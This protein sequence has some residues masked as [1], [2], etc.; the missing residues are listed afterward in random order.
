MLQRP[1]DIQSFIKLLNLWNHC[2][3][4]WRE[5]FQCEWVLVYVPVHIYSL[6]QCITFPLCLS[7]VL[8][9][10]GSRWRYSEFDSKQC[11]NNGFDYDSF[12]RSKSLLLTSR[13]WIICSWR[14]KNQRVWN[15]KWY[16]IVAYRGNL[17]YKLPWCTVAELQ[18]ALSFPVCTSLYATL[19]ERVY[20][21]CVTC[22]RLVCV[23]WD[24][25]VFLLRYEETYWYVICQTHTHIHTLQPHAALCFPLYFTHTNTH[26]CTHKVIRVLTS[27]FFFWM[28]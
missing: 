6:L 27:T 18:I 13:R 16:T 8:H 21:L 7:V 17:F 10:L 3:H 12:I 11:L 28:N 26:I 24:C 14:K 20:G 4:L 1:F 9:H 23:F 22:K 19:A 5:V 15:G 2:F 25:S